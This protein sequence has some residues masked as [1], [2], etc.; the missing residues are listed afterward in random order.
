VTNVGSQAVFDAAMLDRFEV[1]SI[2]AQTPWY[3]NAVTFSG[4][5]LKAVLDAVQAQGRSL[6]VALNDCAA[7]CA[8][9]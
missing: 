1:R 4:P 7:P 5:E 8:D 6:R 9:V 3:P 2:T